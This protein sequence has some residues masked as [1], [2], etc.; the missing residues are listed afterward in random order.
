MT[1]CRSP[2]R[3]PGVRRPVWR[4]G[5]LRL[6]RPWGVPSTNPFLGSPTGGAFKLLNGTVLGRQ[7]DYEKSPG[8]NSQVGVRI[9]TTSPQGLTVTLNYLYQ[10][11]AQDDESPD[12][13]SP[14]DEVKRRILASL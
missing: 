10:R 3:P 5:A 4:R 1:A 14:W 9:G 7:G 8:E 11:I 13:G 2:G 6:P 12:V